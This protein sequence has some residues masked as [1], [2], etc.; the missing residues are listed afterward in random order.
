MSL[1]CTGIS[2]RVEYLD[3]VQILVVVNLV[4]HGELPGTATDFV[5]MLQK[6]P[7]DIIDIDPECHRI[8]D[9]EH[10]P[11]PCDVGR[12]R[13]HALNYYLTTHFSI[14]RVLEEKFTPILK[15]LRGSE[16]NGRAYCLSCLCR[17][18]MAEENS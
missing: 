12:S 14:L 11:V 9:V 6:S 15:S 2:H 13:I 16:A 3:K 18:S 17:H 5:R 7:V 10:A 1:E 8:K 4:R